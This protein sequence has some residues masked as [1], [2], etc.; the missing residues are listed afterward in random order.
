MD[1]D[2]L[3]ELTRAR[4][5][6]RDPEPQPAAEVPFQVFRGPQGEPGRDGVDGKDGKDGLNGKDGRDGIDGRNG[7]DG[8][9]GRPGRDG[10]PGRAGRDGKD[11]KDGAPA[12]FVVRSHM[13]YDNRTGRL[14][15]ATDTMS[16]GSTRY[17]Q[18]QRDGNGRPTNVI[19]S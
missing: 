7:V 10:T 5:A 3:A 13:E 18:V 12:P 19:T 14:V 8:K 17:R 6:Q 15:G 16:D 1:G 4:D 11:G 9:D 2:L